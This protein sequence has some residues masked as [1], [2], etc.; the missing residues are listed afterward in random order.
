MNQLKYHSPADESGAPFTTF[1][2]SVSDG[3]DFS[4]AAA[5]MTINVAEIN[6]PPV[7]VNDVYV[8]LN[9]G[10]PLV[11]S[12][13]NGLLL[14]DFDVDSAAISVTASDATLTQ[15]TLTLPAADG[16][17]EY[18]APLGFIGTDQ[19]TYTVS[20]G[21]D[22]ATATVSIQVIAPG[23]QVVLAPIA[24]TYIDE[25]LPHDVFGDV[26][27][28]PIGNNGT[29]TAALLQFDLT[30]FRGDPSSVLL[31]LTPTATPTGTPTYQWSAVEGVGER[32][33]TTWSSA[34][35]GNLLEGTASPQADGSLSIDVTDVIRVAQALGLEQITISVGSEDSTVVNFASSEHADANLRPRLAFNGAV[36]VNSPPT[37]AN[38]PGTIVVSEDALPGDVIGTVEFS[39]ADNEAVAM[40][41]VG[42]NL[43]GAFTIH[44]YTGVITVA[45]AHVIDAETVSIISA[46][47]CRV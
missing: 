36:K 27:I 33:S 20:D 21:T 24:D 18:T 45:N 41:I 1:D 4:S 19:F 30:Q 29:H 7:A 10:V 11:V 23:N 32:D 15:G 35:A 8:A 47:G 42:G 2:F 34:P 40:R 31:E 5:T 46:H 26:D 17:F 28:L 43:G 3:I 16:S 12:A 25:S 44:P 37:P 39:D 14:N 9:D 13:G 22:T 38:S 6:D